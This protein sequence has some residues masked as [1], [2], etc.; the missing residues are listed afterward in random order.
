VS[1]QPRAKADTPRT[2]VLVSCCGPKLHNPSPAA[3]IYTSD[4]FRKSR[5][6]AELHGDE[7]FILSAKY[8]VLRPDDVIAPYDETLK[9]KTKSEKA[10]WNE[11]VT[12]D[13]RRLA[14][15]ARLV[16]LAGKDYMGWTSYFAKVEKPLGNL[17]IGLRLRWLAIELA[18][19]D[20]QKRG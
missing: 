12:R 10:L 20:K 1:S 13:L 11:K 16:V 19:H 14:D 2:I 8:G 3:D 4:L 9:T 6:W 17:P 18:K 15:G 7:W 5:R